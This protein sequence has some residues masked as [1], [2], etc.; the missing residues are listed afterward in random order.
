M[1][2]PFRLCNEKYW[3][4]SLT[5]KQ[6][7]PKSDGKVEQGQALQLCEYKLSKLGV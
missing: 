7:F 5:K 3:D 1:L 2:P 6:L 4:P